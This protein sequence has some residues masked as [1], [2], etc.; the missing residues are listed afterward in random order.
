MLG[1]SLFGERGTFRQ[2]TLLGCKLLIQQDDAGARFTTT[3]NAFR[4]FIKETHNKAGVKKRLLRAAAAVENDI[5][6]S[7]LSAAPD[8]QIPAPTQQPTIVHS[9]NANLTATEISDLE[10]EE[11][12]AA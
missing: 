4:D 11:P 6:T 12:T 9:L 1:K 5:R 8:H 3:K 10:A 7:V 2:H